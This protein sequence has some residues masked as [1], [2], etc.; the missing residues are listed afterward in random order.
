MCL[1]CSVSGGV[2]PFQ[3]AKKILEIDKLVLLFVYDGVPCVIQSCI[4]D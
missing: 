1:L 4:I 3:A 2:N